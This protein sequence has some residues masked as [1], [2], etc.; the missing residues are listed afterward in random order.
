MA[1]VVDV[2][3]GFDRSAR[4]RELMVNELRSDGDIASP[5]VERAFRVVPRHLFAPDEPLESVYAPD[6][7][8]PV[9]R[10]RSGRMSSCMSAAYL[11]AVML[12]QARIEPGMRVL[13]I[14]SGG[15][16]A[17][18]IA[19]LVGDEGQ[20]TTV[21][22]DGDVT[23]RARRCLDAAGYQRVR[24]VRADAEY[25]V[26][27][28]APYDRVVVTVRSWDIPP[29]WSHQLAPTG[30]IVVPLQL[31]TVT[32][33]IAFDRTGDILTS[34]D[35]RLAVFVPMRGAGA[36]PDHVI[37]IDDGVT[38]RTERPLPGID[39]AA[40]TDAL[41]GPRGEYWS[42]AA[43][44]L[45]DELQL[46]LLTSVEARMVMLHGGDEAIDRGIVTPAAGMGVPALVA[47]DSLA[48][49]TTRDSSEP[50]TDGIETGVIAC[51][52]QADA[53]AEHYV[54][55]L[56]RWAGHYRYRNAATIRYRPTASGTSMPDGWRAPK[57]HGTVVVSW[58]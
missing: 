46:F 27:D 41:H 56:R 49:R 40:L 4:F 21:D 31:A 18:L 8:V 26:P 11:Q 50:G 6:N 24:V 25:G 39:P 42:G 48:W 5:L 14:G 53:L 35:Y 44:D 45:P 29:A 28:H 7:A 19:E 57:Y 38:L 54:A 47:A 20:V 51:G 55:L 22:I 52:P 30:R 58:P 13:E 23:D 16:N 32:R 10:D 34:D 12:E 36:H 17:A 43:F 1:Q 3:A 9:K 37:R 33:V 15:Y 2:P